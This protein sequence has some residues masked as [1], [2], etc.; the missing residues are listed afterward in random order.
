MDRKIEIGAVFSAVT[1]IVYFL[2]NIVPL[3]L[4]S[5]AN[6]YDSPVDFFEKQAQLAS[7]QLKIVQDI[8][9][10]GLSGAVL[11]FVYSKVKK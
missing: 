4:Q 10:S 7:A 2:I 9:V 6:N 8:L 3:S 5:G 1:V 11:S